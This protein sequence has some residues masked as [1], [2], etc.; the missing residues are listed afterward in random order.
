M[1]I[2]AN[3]SPSSPF[4]EAQSLGLSGSESKIKKYLS[5]PCNA[6]LYVDDLVKIFSWHE[7][8]LLL[9]LSRW[10]TSANQFSELVHISFG[11][12]KHGQSTIRLVINSP[13]HILDIHKDSMVWWS[14]L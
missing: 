9:S 8:T 1:R 3:V 14:K 2:G 13:F 7:Q 12:N 4:F 5:L 11:R 10:Q 6:L